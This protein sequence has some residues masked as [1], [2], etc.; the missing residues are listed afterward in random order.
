MASLVDRLRKGGTRVAHIGQSPDDDAQTR[1]RK[2]ALVVAS[3]TIAVFA[4]AWTLVYLALDRPVSA[5]IP[6]TYQVA[7]LIGLS[8]FARSR[9]MH[10]FG[11][12]QVVLMLVLPFLL[13]WSL[14]GFENGSAVMIWAFAAPMGAMVFLGA[15]AA[16]LTYAAF[17]G[18]T[19]V[20]GLIDPT[21]A[22]AAEPVPQ[23]VQQIFFVLDMLG[24][25]FVTFLVL[26]SF[27]RALDRERDRSDQLLRN[28][29]P[30]SIAERLKRGE[31]PI[32]DRLEG[33]TI[34]FMDI[35]GFS[36]L[37][38]RLPP[39]QLVELLDR[40]FGTCDRL[41]DRHGLEK[42]KTVGDSYMAAA[43]APT[44]SAGHAQAAADMALAMG[45]AIVA[46][47]ADLDCPIDVRIGM[48]SGEVVAGV[49]GQRKFSYDLWGAAVNL[50][51]RMESAGVPGAIQVSRA[52][53][54][55]LDG[56][57][58]MEARG[59]VDI[60]GMGPSETWLLT[61]RRASSS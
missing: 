40:V 53:H 35:V 44:P 32:A 37:A 14:G 24:V 46:A 59:S 61:G 9:D 5:A 12:L 16:W 11:T 47:V 10:A 25:S 43:G 30:A 36:P 15:T 20:S 27:V 34:L 38:A 42:I 29:L 4:T 6:F 58:L 49:I 45:P 55:L 28:V 48:H 33:V 22:A 8:W 50:A 13:Q 19:V 21:L 60:K 41:A 56:A 51:S 1:L 17:A 26:I 3:V 23:A 31:R 7:T 39:T 18:L 2:T 54:D 52:T 57:Y